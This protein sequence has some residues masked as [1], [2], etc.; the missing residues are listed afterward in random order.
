M[1]PDLL[2]LGR[3]AVARPR[4][5]WLPGC[6]YVRT[7][8]GG[9]DSGRGRIEDVD[10]GSS[11]MHA[12]PDLSDPASL[13]CLLALVREAWGCPILH[14]AATTPTRLRQAGWSVW[15]LT[16]EGANVSHCMAVASGPTE[17]E[18]L[19]VALERAP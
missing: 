18:A 14:T 13:G 5:R 3:R 4:W 16:F 19:V 6:T 8:P 17:A 12:V 11:P 15:V 7:R 10:Y 2:D 1:S 9:A